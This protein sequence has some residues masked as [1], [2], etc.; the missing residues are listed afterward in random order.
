[1]EPAALDG[2]LR[3]HRA[4]EST[5]RMF[6]VSFV[7]ST[8]LLAGA[9]R[10][11]VPFTTVAEG[12]Q[13]GVEER[14]E[15]VVRTA[16]EWKVLWRQHAPD[17][18]APAVDFDKAMVVGVFAGVRNTGGHSL[19][20]TAIDREGANLV[21]SWHET[22]PPA[23]AI[24]SQVLTFPFHLVRIERSTGAVTFRQAPAVR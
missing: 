24:V 6:H 7:I 11:P 1:M 23:D 14:R 13:S 18:P 9:L 4:D 21:V 17:L 8:L 12:Q 2:R 19:K 20:I 3:G 5:N 15:V 10:V 16:A 22:R